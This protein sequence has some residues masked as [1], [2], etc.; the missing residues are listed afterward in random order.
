MLRESEKTVDADHNLFFLFKVSTY[1]ELFT[2]LSPGLK[3][4]AV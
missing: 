4:D 1:L 2:C 3:V